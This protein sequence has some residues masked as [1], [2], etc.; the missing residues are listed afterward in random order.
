VLFVD[1]DPARLAGRVSER[2][3]LAGGHVVAVR[4]RSGDDR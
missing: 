1:H 4:P 2:W 3:R